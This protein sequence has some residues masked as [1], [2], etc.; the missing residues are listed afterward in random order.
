MFIMS[1][2]PL[3]IASTTDPPFDPLWNNPVTWEENLNSSFVF[4]SQKMFS[5][6]LDQGFPTCGP[7]QFCVAREVIYFHIY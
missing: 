5:N 2:Y 3:A 4:P 6:I 7:R 1:L